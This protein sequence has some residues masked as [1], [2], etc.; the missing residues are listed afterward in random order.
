MVR[1]LRRHWVVAV[2]TA[3]V[4]MAAVV[5]TLAGMPRSYTATAVVA[6][7]PRPEASF[8]GDLIRLTLPSYISVAESP[9]VAR[10]LGRPSR[11]D[12]EL[13]QAG[14]KVENPPGTNILLLSVSWSDPETAAEL[15][16]R[17]ADVVVAESSTD[18]LLAGSVA[19]V[20]VPPN[21]PSW[22]PQ[23]LS[24]VLGGLLSLGL[25][26]AAAWIVDRRRSLVTSA[27]DLVAV[28]DGE[29]LAAPVLTVG[30]SSAGASEFVARAVGMQ[31]GAGL[32][33]SAQV[34]FAVV[35]GAPTRATALAIG[36]AAALSR[37][38]LWVHVRPRDADKGLLV[39]AGIDDE[40]RFVAPGKVTWGFSELAVPVEPSEKDG[41]TSHRAPDVVIR[42]TEGIER[43]GDWATGKSLV[44]VVPVVATEVSDE[45]VRTAVKA[46][47]ASGAPVLA[48]C[49]L[50][51]LTRERALADA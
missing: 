14:I 1:A 2:L 51:P 36:A 18:P 17:L 43:M 28:V 20:A 34:E 47:Q 41:G 5:A 12:P 42:I 9:S 25:G 7:S 19:A 45:Q 27:G 23:L 10:D 30:T 24:L 39:D 50:L 35:G 38:G 44:G 4:A 6:L 13:I 49:Y 15:T 21:E 29:S 33:E 32:P 22:P 48:V 8:S 31:V 46:L 26:L 16:N 3:L 40:L 11:E 37:Q